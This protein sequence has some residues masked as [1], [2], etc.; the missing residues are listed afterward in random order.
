M[1]SNKLKT[2]CGEYVGNGGTVEVLAI[3]FQPIII[4]IR[5]KTATGKTVIGSKS[6]ANAGKYAYRMLIDAANTMGEYDDNN[7]EIKPGGFEVKHQASGA[8]L[9][10]DGITYHYTAIGLD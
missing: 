9:A 5:G 8:S 7:V 6:A 2:H 3:P 1:S 4:E 10:A